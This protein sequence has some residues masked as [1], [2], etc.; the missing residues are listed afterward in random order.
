MSITLPEAAEIASVVDVLKRV[1]KEEIPDLPDDALAPVVG[2]LT[3]AHYACVDRYQTRPD[4]NLW[5]NLL[6]EFSDGVKN[7][8]SL[9]DVAKKKPRRDD[10]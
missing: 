2:A 6:K 4:G 3:G 8:T 1:V 5:G 10:A 9:E 7:A